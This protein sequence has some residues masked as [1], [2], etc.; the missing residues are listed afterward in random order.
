MVT[1]LNPT[2]DIEKSV[3]ICFRAILTAEPINGFK[4]WELMVASK[5]IER[6][7]FFPEFVF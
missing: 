5:R 7:E 2:A 3:P 1:Q 4:K 6:L